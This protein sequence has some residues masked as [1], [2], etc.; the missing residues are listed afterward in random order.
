MLM[1]L[2][3]I[4]YNLLYYTQINHNDTNLFY[5]AKQKTKENI[6]INNNK[7]I[8]LF[9][10]EKQR[11]TKNTQT[12]INNTNKKNKIEYILVNGDLHPCFIIDF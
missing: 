8:K 11:A 4:I 2:I 10:K 1:K 9:S 7:D 3:H 6:Q 5:V 12:I